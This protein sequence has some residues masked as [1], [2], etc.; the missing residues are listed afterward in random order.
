MLNENNINYATF[1][2]RL[3]VIKD[4][5][6]VMKGKRGPGDYYISEVENYLKKNLWLVKLLMKWSL[7]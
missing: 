1:P 2:E 6:I 3:Y 4:D 5:I 7:Q